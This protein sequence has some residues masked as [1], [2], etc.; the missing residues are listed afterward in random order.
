M[1]ADARRLDDQSRLYREALITGSYIALDMGA[2]DVAL[3][4]RRQASRACPL[5]GPIPDASND[6]SVDRGS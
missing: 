6:N 4:L 5:F 2:R 3:A 1:D